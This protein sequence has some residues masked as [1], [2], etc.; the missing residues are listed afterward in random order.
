[1]LFFGAKIAGFLHCKRP[2]EAGQGIYTALPKAAFLRA[3]RTK[4]TPA[5]QESRGAAA[6]M[7]CFL[8]LRL[9]SSEFFR[10]P[11]EKLI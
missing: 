5:F 3:A 9:L 6:R 2:S 10:K 7:D 4:N 11:V 8:L 1:M